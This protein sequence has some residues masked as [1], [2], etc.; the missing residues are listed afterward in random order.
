[1]AKIYSAPEGYEAPKMDFTN[2]NAAAWKKA[3]NDYI[4]R[5]SEW[6][7]GCNPND[8]EYVGQIIKFPVADGNAIYMVAS[9]KP[10]EL[11][12]LELGDAWHFR[13]ANRLTKKD[14]I[15]EVDRLK[16]IKELFANKQK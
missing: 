11:I 7:K 5:L 4:A 1:M 16:A 12:H 6:C 8:P 14:V 3:D 15:K 13:F 2:F 9:L 10:V